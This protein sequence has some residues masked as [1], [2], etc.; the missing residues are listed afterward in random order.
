M[1]KDLY[2]E[3]TVKAGHEAR[4]AELMTEMTPRVRAEPGNVAFLPYN[5]ARDPR[6]WFVLE[7][8]ADEAAFHTHL[9]APFGAVFNDEIG[10]H[11]EENATQLTMLT[12]FAP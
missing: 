3:F 9:S 11:I 2:A 4:V 1:T 5:L 6:K 10:E 8:Y 7:I 12:R